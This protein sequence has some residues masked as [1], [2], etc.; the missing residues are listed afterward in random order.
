MVDV[1]RDDRPSARYLRTDEFR[2]ETLAQGDELHLRGHLAL[3]GVVHLGCGPGATHDRPVQRRRDLLGA[4]S[5][6]GRQDLGNVAARGDP[7]TTQPRQPGPHV[8]LVGTARVVH[9]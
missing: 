7:V 8:C 4:V 3:A 2:I 1:G 6:A 5:T 9:P